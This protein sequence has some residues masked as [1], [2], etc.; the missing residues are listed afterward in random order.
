MLRQNEIVLPWIYYSRA[1]KKNAE[2]FLPSDRFNTIDE[3]IRTEW[4]WNT[5]STSTIQKIKEGSRASAN[6]GD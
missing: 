6:L 2:E 5:S 4:D 3:A 1:W